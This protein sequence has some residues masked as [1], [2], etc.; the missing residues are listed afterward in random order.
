MLEFRKKELFVNFSKAQGD[1][2]CISIADGFV[3]RFCVD[4]WIAVDIIGK[5][6]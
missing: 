1:L 5:Q 6:F 2:H 4:M 3:Y